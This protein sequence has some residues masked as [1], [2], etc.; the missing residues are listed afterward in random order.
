MA[1]W[2]FLFRQ[3]YYT[4]LSFKLETE[5][6]TKLEDGRE[7]QNISYPVLNFHLVHRFY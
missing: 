5:R 7:K 4:R 3:V 1:E 2:T 6:K